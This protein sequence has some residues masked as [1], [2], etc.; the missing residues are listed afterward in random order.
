MPKRYCAPVDRRL[1]T[2]SIR[3]NRFS[4]HHCRP[5]DVLIAESRTRRCSAR[6]PAKELDVAIAVEP[7]ESLDAERHAALHRPPTCAAGPGGRA[8]GSREDA[9]FRGTG[10]ADS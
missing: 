2:I 9:I 5:N 3:K 6:G 1:Q 10:Q 4:L 8:I 7:N